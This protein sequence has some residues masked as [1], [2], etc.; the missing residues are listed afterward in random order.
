MRLAL[1]QPNDFDFCKSLYGNQSVDMLYH[2][3]D[4]ETTAENV[5]QFSSEY[6]I[7][8]EIWEEMVKETEL[9]RERFEEQLKKSYTRSFIIYDNSNTK[10]GY[11]IIAKLTNDRNCWKLN[12]LFLKE[13][14][15][16][17][18]N[19]KLVIE[20]LFK[21]KY[22]QTIQVCILDDYTRKNFFVIGFIPKKGSKWFLKKNKQSE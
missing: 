15:Q 3:E 16:N 22:V 8:E 4:K 10:I 19:F 20:L 13:D 17:F 6:F 21:N 2:C 14:S 7:T 12:F 5:A 1:A 18:E 9:T 11:C